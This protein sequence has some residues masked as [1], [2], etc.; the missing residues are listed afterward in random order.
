MNLKDYL[1]EV[2]DHVNAKF[3]NQDSTTSFFYEEV[4]KDTLDQQK[5]IVHEAIKKGYDLNL[6]S[7]SDQKFME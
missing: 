3:T 7:K 4:S 6:I 2:S 1:I 5:A